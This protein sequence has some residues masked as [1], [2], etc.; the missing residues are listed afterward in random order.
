MNRT[1]R[2]IKHVTAETFFKE[3]A[4]ATT[5]DAIRNLTSTLCA[6]ALA[7]IKVGAEVRDAIVGLATYSTTPE[8]VENQMSVHATANISSALSYLVVDGV[9]RKAL[10]LVCDDHRHSSRFPCSLQRP[11]RAPLRTTCRGCVVCDGSNAA[12]PSL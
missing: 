9:Q 5:P 8:A 10:F 3:A 6:T 2:T 7:G 11:L 12:N 4:S 1:S